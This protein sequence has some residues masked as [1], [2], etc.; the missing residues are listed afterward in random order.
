LDL[1]RCGK[2]DV[3]L[4]LAVAYDELVATERGAVRT[5]SRPPAALLGTYDCAHAA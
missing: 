3:V 1:I 5:A 2:L 4:R